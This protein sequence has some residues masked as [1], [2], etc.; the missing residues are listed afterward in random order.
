MIFDNIKNAKQY[1]SLGEGIKKGFEFIL[2]NDL[3]SLECGKYEIS[4][5]IYANVQELETKMPHEAKFEAH[6]QYIDIQYVILGE[7]RMD[8]SLIE[9]FQTQ[10]AYDEQKDV[11]FLS[12]KEDALCPNT[13]NVKQTD[14]AIFYPQDAHAPML[15]ASDKQI[16]IKKVIVKIPCDL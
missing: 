8:F 7:E 14:F 3:N 16:N 13:I 12:L 9:N 4:D 5:G 10:I 6:R 11:E 2:N 15:S 1:F